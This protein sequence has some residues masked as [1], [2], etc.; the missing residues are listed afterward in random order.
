MN[1]LAFLYWRVAMC[2]G[3][4]D[5]AAGAGIQPWQLAAVGVAFALGNLGAIAYLRNQKQD[6]VAWLEACVDSLARSAGWACR[7][8]SGGESGTAEADAGL[9]PNR[10]VAS[11]AG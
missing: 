8:R 11:R 6:S 7:S 2:G 5:R 4:A 1:A 10:A 3:G 9:L